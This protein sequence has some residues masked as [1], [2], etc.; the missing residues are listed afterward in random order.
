M[1]AVLACA[2]QPDRVSLTV[3]T[4]WPWLWERLGRPGDPPAA[5]DLLNA[6]VGAR[7]VVAVKLEGTAPGVRERRDLVGYRMDPS[8]VD[9]IREDAWEKVRQATAYS[10]GR[11][12]VLSAEQARQL[13]GGEDS[14]QVV[15]AA[16]NAA[17]YLLQAGEWEEAS[18]MLESV[19]TRHAAPPV[20]NTVVTMYRQV[21]AA[22]GSA[23][24]QVILAR[25]LAASGTAAGAAEAQSLYRDALRLFT[26]EGDHRHASGVALEL[27]ELLTNLG[28]YAE[29]T[30]LL[31]DC[32]RA[33]EDNGDAA[34][35]G[36]ARSALAELRDLPR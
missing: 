10:F 5:R 22:T 36:K 26:T 8:V 4:V 9:A 19:L 14:V 13:A 15:A 3:E 7:L 29:A 21:V 35:A 30:E 20:V 27:A 31:Q 16:L 18:V 23:R 1:A 2:N 24:H 33:F 11:F 28:R 12:W 32:L 6:L 17:P 25:G 34:M